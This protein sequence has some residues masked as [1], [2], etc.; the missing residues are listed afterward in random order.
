M[1]TVTLKPKPTG[2]EVG[3]AMEH[4]RRLVISVRLWTIVAVLALY[5]LAAIVVV[6]TVR[7][8]AGPAA[9]WW[10]DPFVLA[11]RIL[12]CAG[13]LVAVGIATAGAVLLARM[14]LRVK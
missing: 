13:A 5:A 1:G 2:S 9:Y 6:I 11:S 12:M 10:R 3:V 7:S 4:G 14:S 8:F